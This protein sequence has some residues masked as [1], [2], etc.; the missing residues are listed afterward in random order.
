MTDQTGQT[1]Q[2]DQIRRFAL[3]YGGG[4]RAFA[5]LTALGPRWSSVDLSADALQV[6]MG[7]GFQARIPRRSIT[8]AR[9][10]GQPRDIW[11]AVGIHT[12]GG[13][14]I[15]NGS[16]HGVVTLAIEPPVRARALG[17]PIRLRWLAMSLRDP[18]G[19]L[20]ALGAPT[21]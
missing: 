21:V 10:L 1:D 20:A 17:L 2:T 11:Y 6:R 12:L 14:W 13:R 5:S 3:R 16:L 7:W 9:R 15:V 8:Q 19:F 4:M 18:D